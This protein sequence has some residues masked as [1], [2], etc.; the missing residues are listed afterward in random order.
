MKAKALGTDGRTAASRPESASV[1]DGPPR[2]VQT[3]D[4]Q[5]RQTH[6]RSERPVSTRLTR[7]Y[8]QHK[9]LLVGRKKNALPT[10]GL[11][12]GQT[13]ARSERAASSR[14]KIVMKKV[15]IACPWRFG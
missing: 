10:D 9:S 3:R 14:L 7:P 5:T 11:R 4:R 6:T 15:E 8:T 1:T 12:D 2:D 13:D